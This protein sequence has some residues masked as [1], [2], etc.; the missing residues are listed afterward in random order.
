LL[1]FS[2]KP[3]GD[4]PHVF[5]TCPT[6]GKIKKPENNTSLWLGATHNRWVVWGLMN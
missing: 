4:F 3:S 6:C 1:G 2:K 5:P